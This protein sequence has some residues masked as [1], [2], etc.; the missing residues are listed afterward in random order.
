MSYS[1]LMEWGEYL[2]LYPLHE[3]RSEFQMAVL[4]TINASSSK[5]QYEVN[6]FMVTNKKKKVELSGKDLED[7]IFKAMG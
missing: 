5:K 7:Y 3:D 2:S 1:E 6:D 4:S